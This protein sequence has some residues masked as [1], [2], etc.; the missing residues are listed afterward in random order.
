[1]CIRACV[2]TEDLHSF[3]SSESRLLVKQSFQ[4]VKAGQLS[5]G[6]RMLN[7]N[8]Q[9]SALSTHTNLSG[10]QNLNTVVL[11]RDQKLPDG[12]PGRKVYHIY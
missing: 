9:G 12:K 1:M 7:T 11:L 3:I 10:M 8:G 4:A 6:C 5:A 2:R